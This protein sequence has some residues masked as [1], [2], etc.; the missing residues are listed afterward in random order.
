MKNPKPGDSNLLEQDKDGLYIH[1]SNYQQVKDKMG[2]FF[3][4]DRIEKL[5]KIPKW[6]RKI[7]N[8]L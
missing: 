8:A 3:H 6:I 1:A 2:S 4:H 5:D 7:F